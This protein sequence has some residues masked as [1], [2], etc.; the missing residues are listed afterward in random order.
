MHQFSPK[1]EN[2]DD[3]QLVR[4][5]R[6]A[7]L[8]AHDAFAGYGE[9]QWSIL[10]GYKSAI[11]NI[12]LNGT[13]EELASVLRNPADNNLFFGFDLI[14]ESRT[15]AL[16][17]D[18]VPQAQQVGL[19]ADAV[20]ALA[21]AIGVTRINNPEAPDHRLADAH[22]SDELI[23]M[24]AEVVQA[25]FPNPY[26]NEFGLKLKTGIANLRAVFAVYQ[27]F[28]TLQMLRLAKGKSV[29]EIGAGLG[30][31]AYYCNR[32]GVTGYTIIDLPM[33]NLAQ[34]YF[35][36]RALGQDK[37]SLFGE[38]PAHGAVR[39]LPTVCLGDVKADVVVNVDSLT[40]MDH[41]VAVA[42]VAHTLKTAKLFLSINH[43]VNSF[44]V[45]ELV[46]GLSPTTELMRYPSPM[47]A[48]Y[49]EEIVFI[50]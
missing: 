30:R 21:G 3:I 40:E 32:S 7:Y 23:A 13:D 14:Y 34:G 10:D 16:W 11:H 43:E 18:A 42:Y 9:S 8:T 46:K 36:G 45:N 39:V 49:V 19:V 31:T 22:T 29:L 26:P 4:R 48:G 41:E 47:R 35:L 38:E 5:L 33:T 24:V 6:T 12:A 27:Q 25:D 1:V 50:R 20:K 17:A 37:V 2:V 44:T 15:K 28:R